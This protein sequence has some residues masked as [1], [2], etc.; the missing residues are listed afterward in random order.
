VLAGRRQAGQTT[1]SRRL[2][3][4]DPPND[5]DLGLERLAVI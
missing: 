5:F 4:N 3:S 2:L 1:L